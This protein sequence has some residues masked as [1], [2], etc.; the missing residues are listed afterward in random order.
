V[1]PFFGIPSGARTPDEAQGCTQ[2]TRPA[3]N[4]A[5]ILLVISS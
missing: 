1:E 3:S 4:S 5:M 2:G